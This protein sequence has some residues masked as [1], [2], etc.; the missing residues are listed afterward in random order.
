MVMKIME[1]NYESGDSYFSVDDWVKKS[2]TSNRFTE[3]WERR[4]VE[5]ATAMS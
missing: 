3:E 5:G 2:N 1:N 4:I